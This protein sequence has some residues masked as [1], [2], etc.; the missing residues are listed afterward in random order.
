MQRVVFILITIIFCLE[1]YGQKPES[2]LYQV[3]VNNDKGEVMASKQVDLRLTIISGIPSGPLVYS[4]SQTVT[5]DKDG[6]VTLDVGTGSNRIS[7]VSAINWN[8]GT[9]FIKVEADLE[10]T[11]KY[12]ELYTTQLLT[13][14]GEGPKKSSRR[15][16]ETVIEEQ[17]L[18]TRKYVGE[19]LDFRHTGSDHTNGPNIV[20]IKTSLDKTY[21]KFS[22]YSKKCDFKKGDKLYLRRIYYSPGDVTGYWVYQIEN[23]ASVFYRLTDLQYDKKVYVETLFKQ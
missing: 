9:Y 16:G 20:W 13:V 18:M 15:S 14:A 1:G 19:F 4:E 10:G 17:F 7:S 2:F 6:I 3:V 21:G 12:R 5:T 23:N 8:S 11:H 22:V